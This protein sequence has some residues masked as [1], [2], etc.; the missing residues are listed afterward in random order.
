MSDHHYERVDDLTTA[1]VDGLGGSDDL[2]IDDLATA[3]EFHLGGAAATAAIIDALAMAPADRVLD[4]GS[5][6]GGPARRIAA[7]PARILAWLVSVSVCT[8]SASPISTMRT[9]PGR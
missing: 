9:D 4:I 8:M 1:I 5:G 6:L 7:T 2:T 3:D